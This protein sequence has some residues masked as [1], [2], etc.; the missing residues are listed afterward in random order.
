MTP[1]RSAFGASPPGGRPQQPG[2][3]GSAAAAGLAAAVPKA[4]FDW[5]PLALLV[6]LILRGCGLAI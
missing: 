1:P 6:A 3:A 4:Q 2:E 5:R